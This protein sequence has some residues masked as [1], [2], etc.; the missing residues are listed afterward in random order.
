[1]RN[2]RAVRYDAC[3]AAAGA[4]AVCW[5]AGRDELVAAFGPSEHAPQVRL[6]RIVVGG[7]SE[8]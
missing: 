8:L 6:A 4:S 5:D 7:A 2:L 1:M 3:R